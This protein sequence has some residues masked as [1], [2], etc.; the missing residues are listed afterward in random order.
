MPALS[1]PSPMTA[2]T[3]RRCPLRAA[4][5]AMP[6][7]ALIDVLEWPTPNVSYSLSLR[8]GNGARPFLSLIVRSWSRRPVS[9]LCG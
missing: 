9:T 5:I 7:A 6:S 1:A 3:R 4:A 8:V 2:T